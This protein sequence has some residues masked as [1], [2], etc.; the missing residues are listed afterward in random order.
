MSAALTEQDRLE[1]QRALELAEGGRGRVSP[2]PLVGAVLV[3][4]GEVIGQGF[5]AELGGPHAE[6]AAIEDCRA[7]GVDP[8]GATMYVTL[9]PCAH[10]GRQPPCASAILEARIARVVIASDDPSE[11]ASGRGPGILRD[12][13]VGVEVADGPEAAAARLLNQAFR[14]HARTGRPLVVLK[15]ALSLDGRV[16]TAGGDSK[17][18]SGEAS[19][20]L[21]HGW[22]AEADAVCIGIGTALADDPLLT[23]RDRAD[24]R[25]PTRVVFDSRAR[26]PFASKLVGSIDAAPLVVIAGPAAPFERT[27]ALK[28][29][30]AEVIVCDGDAE[31][32]VAAALAELG[33]RGLTS[34]LLEGGPTL[35]G[36][37]LD[38]GEIDELRLFIAPIVIG[39]AG[40]RP[41]AAGTGAARIAEAIPALDMEWERS[42]SELLV[43]A[44]LR[45]W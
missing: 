12:E 27:E 2:N 4:D 28:A 31:A 42:G 7:R 44:R 20:R 8:A 35:T 24:V 5:H 14:K 9:E 16:A 32:L 25:Q 26:L 39:G 41:L 40:A 30:G 29:T 34:V 37:F 23:A 45:E 43:R 38:A 11:K 21:A 10:H 13:G 15:S 19:R 33:R 6:V 36:S 17:W 22:R 18:I 1:L 3:R